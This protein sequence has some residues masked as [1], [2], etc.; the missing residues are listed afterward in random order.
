MPTR[1]RSIVLFTTQIALS[2]WTYTTST[3]QKRGTCISEC[4][5][6]LKCWT[7]CG[8]HFE[9]ACDEQFFLDENYFRSKMSIMFSVAFALLQLSAFFFF[10]AEIIFKHISDIN[11]P[12]SRRLRWYWLRLLILYLYADL[13]CIANDSVVDALT[14]T[15]SLMI[16]LLMPWPLL[17]R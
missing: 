10:L 3:V 16:V 8:L 6:G 2:L 12:V 14:F 11:S 13:Y 15:V 4:Y 5:L 1:T 17:Y 9:D 7:R